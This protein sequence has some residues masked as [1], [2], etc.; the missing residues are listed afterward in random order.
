MRAGGRKRILLSRLLPKTLSWVQKRAM[1][2]LERLV[3]LQRL[4]DRLLLAL[5][6]LFFGWFRYHRLLLQL[7]L[8]LV[9]LSCRYGTLIRV[10]LRHL[11]PR[12]QH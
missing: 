6:L 9:T 12:H 5:L 3:L 10:F 8:D 11:L 4:D 7:Q 1:E 2:R